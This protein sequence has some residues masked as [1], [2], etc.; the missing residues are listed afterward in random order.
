[1]RFDARGHGR[2]DAWSED[3]YIPYPDGKFAFDPLEGHSEFRPLP[4]G[5][6]ASS[7]FRTRDKRVANG[8]MVSHGKGLCWMVDADGA[9][10]DPGEG[11]KAGV[12][13][14]VWTE[15]MHVERYGKRYPCVLAGAREHGGD[16][17]AKPVEGQ[18]ELGTM[19][20]NMR[21]ETGRG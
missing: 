5:F 18:G 9:P 8:G 4:A 13:I 12:S 1:M 21:A 10:R 14:D 19:L 17:E 7:V 2:P 11:V 16:E 15:R 6:D 20:A 3:C